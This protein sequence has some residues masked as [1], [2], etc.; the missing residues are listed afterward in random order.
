MRSVRLSR[1]KF[2]VDDA[3]RK[4]GL[5][6]TGHIKACCSVQPELSV[7]SM[8]NQSQELVKSVL[9]S[10]SDD[11]ICNR[12]VKGISPAIAV[13]INLEKLHGLIEP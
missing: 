13:D 2:C 12:F 8:V 7:W 3:Y 6:L 10:V 1:F 5:C 11:G 4:C 9:H